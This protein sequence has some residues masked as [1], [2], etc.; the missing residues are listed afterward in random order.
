M[1]GSFMS[2][3]NI[4]R[5]ILASL[6]TATVLVLSHLPEE[7]ALFQLRV[8]GIDKVEHVFVY[9]TITLL[10]ILSLRS[11]S[12]ALHACFLFFGVLTLG[13]ID[14]LTQALVSRRASFGDWLAD[15]A[16]VG[17]VTILS[18]I[19]KSALPRADSNN[20]GLI[21]RKHAEGNRALGL[22]HSDSLE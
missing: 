2:H 7:S 16:G 12:F 1:A 4:K 6:F 9:G 21:K 8:S 3:F 14:E 18:L 19:F 15:A 22:S 10:F 17:S 20:N 5:L 11:S 13:A